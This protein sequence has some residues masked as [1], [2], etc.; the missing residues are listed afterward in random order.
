MKKTWIILLLSAVLALTVFIFRD[1]IIDFL[2]IDQ[3]RWVEKD[4]NRYLL[5]EDG[6]PRAGWYSAEGTRYYFREDGVMH[7]G[8]LEEKQGRYYFGSNGQPHTGWLELDGVSHYF[9]SDGLLASGLLEQNGKRFYLDENGS[10]VAGWQLVGEKPCYVTAEGTIPSGWLE[11]DGQKYYLTD[12]GFR[13]SGWLDDSNGRYYFDSEGL[14]TTGWVTMGGK[15]YYMDPQGL[16][17]QGWAEI[18]GDTYYFDESGCRCTGWLE[19]DGKRHYIGPDGKLKTGWHEEDGNRYYLLADGTPAVGKLEIDGQNFFFSS[20]GVNFI[21]VNPWNPLP[22]GFEAELIEVPGAWLD[23]VCQ[24]AFEKMLEDCRAAGYNPR[25]ISSYRSIA[26]QTVNL[27]NMV[28][29]YQDRGYS[30]A[31]AYEAATQIVAVPGT[32]EHHLGLAFDIV[33]AAYPKL[34]HQQ[35]QMPAQQWLMEHCWEYGFILR[36]PENTTDI[37]GI[38]WEPW[39]YRYVGVE[40]ALEIRDLGCITLEEYIDSLTK[41]GTTCARPTEE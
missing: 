7:T 33:D 10:P 20:S 41:D 3:S 38:I 36:Y 4:G 19:R 40:I 13:Y 14:L 34:N 6:D 35:A 21:M 37:T 12:R 39:H 11:L 17:T 24:E 32:S 18:D 25:I 27:A 1:P 30:Y 2:P 9:G 31:L 5:D 16:M 8:W 22:E 26:D 29:S 28:R 15:L 23:P